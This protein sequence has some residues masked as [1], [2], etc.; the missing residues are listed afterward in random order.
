MSRKYSK[1]LFKKGDI[2]IRHEFNEKIFLVLKDTY[3]FDKMVNVFNIG[4]AT[5][6]FRDK[7]YVSLIFNL[8][9]RNK[10]VKIINTRLYPISDKTLLHL[11]ESINRKDN[12][13]YLD[14]IWRDTGMDLR[15]I[16]GY[17]NYLIN[18]EVEK[19]NL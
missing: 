4:N 18:L 17:Q 11:Y 6:N 7:K 15:K 10:R 2:I 8:I 14:I 16:K 13:I 3:S 12:E 9:E 5:N 1:I 19:Y